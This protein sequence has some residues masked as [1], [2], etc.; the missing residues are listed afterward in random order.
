[1]VLAEAAL[2][3]RLG[4]GSA[5]IGVGKLLA[6]LA[7]APNDGMPVSFIA[8]NGTE[9]VDFLETVDNCCL[10]EE[11]EMDHNLKWNLFVDI[12]APTTE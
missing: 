5:C 3:T 11:Q 8:M 6:F 4:L 1:M 10:C 9:Q 2:K 7:R 12:V